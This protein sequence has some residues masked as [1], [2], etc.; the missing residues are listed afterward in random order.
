MERHIIEQQ[1]R[2]AV[3]ASGKSRYRIAMET[4]VGQSALCRFV[5]GTGGLSLKRLGA[6]ARAVGLEIIVKHVEVHHGVH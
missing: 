5:K 1:I 6:V 4:G 3:E 2:Q